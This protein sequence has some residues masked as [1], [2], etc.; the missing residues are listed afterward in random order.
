MKKKLLFTAYSLDIGGIETSLINL[1]KRLDYDKYEVT[2]ILEKKEG[3]FLKEVPSEVKV[4]EYKI[5]NDK[6][7][8]TRKLK[9]RTKLIKLVN[10]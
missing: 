7:P 5:S 3:L 6:N 4:L 10:K 9:N 2:L 1:L 8:V